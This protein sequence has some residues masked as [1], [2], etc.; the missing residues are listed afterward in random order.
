V[1]DEIGIQVDTE[2]LLNVQL[3]MLSHLLQG[4]CKSKEQMKEEYKGQRM[5]LGRVEEH[6]LLT[7]VTTLEKT[8]LPPPAINSCL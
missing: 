1:R 3:Y 5:E 6:F 8:S 4:S 2:M 7:S